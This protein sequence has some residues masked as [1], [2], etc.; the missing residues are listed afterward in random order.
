VLLSRIFLSKLTFRKCGQ[1]HRFSIR[2]HLLALVLTAVVP[3]LV[4][5]AIMFWREVKSQRTAVER[6]MRDTAR[7]LVL[8]VD[9]EVASMRAVGETLAESPHL[10]AKDF[11]S[12]YE[13][14]SRASDKRTGSWVVLFDHSGQQIINTQ[15][16]FGD[17]L[18]NTFKQGKDT[19]EQTT[20]ELSLGTPS[21]VKK[22]FETGHSL[23][24]DLFIGLVSK[25]PT[26]SIN[27]PVT[28]HGKVLYALNTGI[29]PEALT[30]L[31]REQ[32]LPA[33]WVAVLVDKKGIIIARTLDPEKYVGQ[34]TS[35]KLINLLAE[36]SEGFDTGYIPEGV[37][38][39]FSYA[40]SKL[41]GW[42]I[43]I[44]APQVAIDAPVNRSMLI[45]AAGSAVL[46][47][48][49]LSAAIALGRR[50]SAPISTLANSADAIQSGVPVEFKPSSVA[51]VTRLHEALL[52][53]GSTA[54]IAAGERERR[55]VAEAKQ[56][57]ADAAREKVLESERRLRESEERFRS[58][59]ENAPIG[60]AHVGLDGRWSRVNRALCAILDCSSE[61]LLARTFADVT[62]P[63]DLEKSWDRL[64]SLKSGEI[65]TYSIEKRYVRKDGSFVWVE[66]TVSLA[67]DSEGRPLY[68]IGAVED[69][70]DRIAAHEA[71]READRR[72]DD[73]L[74][75]LGHELRNPLG[76]IS[77]VVQLLRTNGPSDPQLQEFRDIIDAEVG[78]LSRLL[79]DLLDVSRIARG[80]IRLKKEPCDFATIVRQ[81]TDARR[82]TLEKKGIKSFLELPAHPVWVMG[83]GTRLAQ[84]VGNLLDNANK[85]TEPGGE[86]RV[87][88]VEEANAGAAVL[89]VVDTGIGVEAKFLKTLFEPFT[90]ADRSLDRSR[91]GG[92]GLGL[93]LVKG[94]VEL[95]GGRVSAASV[96][97]GQGSEFTVQL[98][99]ADQRDSHDQ[100]IE[101]TGSLAAPRRILIIEDNAKAAQTLRTYLMGLGHNVEMAQNGAEGIAT[102]HQFRPEVV[103]CD[104]GLPGLDGYAVAQIL[105]QDTSSNG[106]CLIAVSGYG[107]EANQRRALEAGFNAYLIKPIDLEKLRGLLS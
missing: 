10:D 81:V 96:G 29:L 98:P 28:R 107:Q 97:L 9:R 87:Q 45:M 32:R 83:D 84:I 52:E 48:V 46:L 51:E 101:C 43:A 49:A 37:P 24:S 35:L 1:P 11:K 75:M 23:I 90:Q 72:K 93:P 55:I 78:Q 17:S 60:M 2:M 69:I 99:L 58:T 15:R 54:H 73:F 56:A 41:T 6:G 61:E 13:L 63:D 86:V 95:Q 91:G 71:L 50:I 8:A 47:L 59:F 62:H 79:D 53:A 7:A 33:D 27:V 21:S 103:I 36:S 88:L 34:L 44:G 38:V 76:V 66:V 19:L 65:P 102:A 12:F 25:R 57:E 30:A 20:T 40:R 92:L 4:L 5:T 85:Y 31:L 89:K 94:L 70:S 80:V 64:E 77:T 67:L 104:I 14:S 74:A 82:S 26:L 16:P 3:L 106:I 39:Y 22:V 105:R 42:G 100:I 68:F 18:P